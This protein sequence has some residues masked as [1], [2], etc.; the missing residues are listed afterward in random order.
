MSEVVLGT[1]PLGRDDRC[2]TYR[3]LG[4]DKPIGD[5]NRLLTGRAR[6]RLGGSTP[7]TPPSRALSPGYTLVLVKGPSMGTSRLPA[8]AE[9]RVP[10]T[11]PPSSMG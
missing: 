1:T 2:F 6:E 5:G 3:K 9:E 8:E 7:L 11:R 4:S 10:V